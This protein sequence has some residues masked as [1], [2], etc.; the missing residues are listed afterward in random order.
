MT[1]ILIALATLIALAAVAYASGALYKGWKLVDCHA[2]PPMHIT[3]EHANGIV[4]KTLVVD[5]DDWWECWDAFQNPGDDFVDALDSNGD[6]DTTDAGE[7][8]TVR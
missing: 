4:Q 6:S 8:V 7:Y 5:P 1:R 2:G 3:I